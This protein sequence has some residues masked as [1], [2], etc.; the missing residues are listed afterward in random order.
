MK[1]KIKRETWRDIK[2]YLF[3]TLLTIAMLMASACGKDEPKCDC[4]ATT[5]YNDGRPVFT[6]SSIPAPC[7]WDGKIEQ[8][9]DEITYWSC[10]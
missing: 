5:V 3:Y 10:Q 2:T 8:D 4:V 9:E 6:S 7:D 1:F